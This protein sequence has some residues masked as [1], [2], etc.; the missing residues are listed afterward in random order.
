MH[1]YILNFH[2]CSI[3]CKNV[4]FTHLYLYFPLFTDMSCIILCPLLTCH[5]M[6]KIHIISANTVFCDRRA[7]FNGSLCPGLGMYSIKYQVQSYSK[8]IFIYCILQKWSK[9][10]NKVIKYI[11]IFTCVPFGYDQNSKYEWLR[12]VLHISSINK[13]KPPLS[14]IYCWN[15]YCS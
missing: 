6:Q 11:F 1:T 2:N 9:C 15:S 13:R 5:L 14:Y 3:K 7:I 12:Y 10:T 4:L 8:P